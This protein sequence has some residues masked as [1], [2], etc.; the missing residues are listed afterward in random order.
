[1]K[2]EDTKK[3]LLKAKDKDKI[4]NSYIIYGGREEE[5]REVAIFFSGILNCDKNFCK[6]CE[7]CKKIITHTHP[8]L[9]FIVPEKNILSIDEVREVKNDIFTKPYYNKYKIYIFEIEYIKEEAG[10]AFLKIIEEPPEYGIIIILTPNINFLLPTV[11]SR[12][13]KIYINYTIPKY[14]EE[15]NKNKEELIEFI[16][17]LKN[18]KFWEFFKKVDAFCK[19]KEREEIEGWIESIIFFLRDS[20]FYNHRFPLELLIYKNFGINEIMGE[21]DIQNM[22]KI[23]EIKQRVKY[24]I[25]LK[26][27]LEN[28]LFCMYEYT[29]EKW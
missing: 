26:L 17:L 25:N 19:N 8:D 28:L 16:E 15:F 27:A 14:K 22:E 12:C 10:S 29:R 11:T 7:I 5:R 1:M 24:N 2:L 4:Q 21:I 9:R 3:I 23:W 20:F 13:S 6:K 18:K